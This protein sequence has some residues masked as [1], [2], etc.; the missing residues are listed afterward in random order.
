M[1]GAARSVTSG[2]G[3][4]SWQYFQSAC[5][6]KDMRMLSM[7]APGV[8]SPNFVPRSYTKLNS[9]YRPPRRRFHATSSG[10]KG[11][12]LRAA[13]MGTKEG[14]KDFCGGGAAAG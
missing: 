7:R 3:R 2:A 12:F 11:V 9:V 10:V 1:A 5:S 8:C 13:R 4:T 14:T 6:G